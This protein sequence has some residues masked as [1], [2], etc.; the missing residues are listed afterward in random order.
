MNNNIG[1]K[2][3]I[4]NKDSEYFGEWGIIKSFDGDFYHVAIANGTDSLPIF[5]RS[6]IQIPRRQKGENNE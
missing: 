5:D 3:Y 1:K 2:C 4:K 6:E